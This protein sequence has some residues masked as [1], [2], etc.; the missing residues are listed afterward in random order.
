MTTINTQVSTILQ[1]HINGTATGNAKAAISVG[2]TQG[3]RSVCRNSPAAVLSN[4]NCTGAPVD[5]QPTATVNGG[6]CG[7]MT[8]I[9]TQ[10]SAIL[11][12]H[13]TGTATGNAK[14]A[15]S[16]GATQGGR[17]VCR[18]SPAAVLGNVNCT[19]APVD[20]QATT[21]VNGGVRGTTADFDNHTAS[22]VN[23][24]VCG[25]SAVPDTHTAVIVNNGVRSSG[26]VVE[27][28][29][30][31]TVNGG[32][33]DTTTSDTLNSAIIN[34][35]ICGTTAINKLGSTV[36]SGICGAASTGDRL[37]SII[38]NGGICRRITGIQQ[39]GEGRSF[40]PQDIIIIIHRQSRS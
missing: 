6:A 4:V 28:L 11:Q 7:L 21:T 17:S 24:S 22:I 15:V 10:V 30:P 9:N 18:N 39:H 31:A 8:T 25:T 37:A 12:Q 29:P 20:G 26:S 3:G 5:R 36:Y 38:V 16:V 40:V 27:P 1:Q 13:I 35:C 2:A 23:N 19:G 34:G 14:A 33:R 32:I